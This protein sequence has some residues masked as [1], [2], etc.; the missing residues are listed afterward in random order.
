MAYQTTFWPIAIVGEDPAD[1]SQRAVR[2]RTIGT[3]ED[4]LRYYLKREA[5][6]EH[7]KPAEFVCACL[8]DAIHLAVPLFKLARMPDGEIVFASREEAGVSPMSEWLAELTSDAPSSHAPQLSRWLAFDAFVGN[9]DRHL[10]NFLIRQDHGRHELL[11]IDFSEALWMTA[12]GWPPPRR[13]PPCSTLRERSQIAEKFP[14]N[15]AQFSSLL[16]KIR[17][18][19]DQWMEQTLSHLPSG[20]LDATLSQDVTQWWVNDRLSRTEAI[21]EDMENGYY[22]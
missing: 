22:I 4:G 15:K 11:G 10:D 21:E 6:G 13:L 9:P 18:L 20:W 2:C 8:A 16:R 3:G 7:L 12:S 17:E 5:N 1:L 14:L 19:P